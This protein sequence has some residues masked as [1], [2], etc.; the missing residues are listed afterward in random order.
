[1]I[2][3]ARNYKQAVIA[4]TGAYQY[5]DVIV[6]AI[7]PVAKNASDA[8]KT[9]LMIDQFNQELAKMC[10]DEG[11]KYLNLTEAL[12]DSNSGYAEAAY[13]NNKQNG[14][15]TSG[16]NVVLN[17][18]RN[19]AYD[20]AD[21]RPNTDDI[22]QRTEQAGGSAA[23]TEP[24]PS[25]TPTTFKL[26][27]LVEEGK[28]TLQGNDQSGVTS[29]EMDAAEKQTV[30]ITAVA[31]DGYTFYKWSDGL[32]TATRVDSATKDISVTA[33]FNDARVQINLDQGESTIKQGESLTINASVTLGGKSYDNSGVQWSVNDDLMQN[34]A[35]LYLYAECHRRLP[36]QGRAGSQRYLYF[37]GT[38]GACA[39]TGY[40]RQHH[41]CQLHAG[42]QYHNAAGQR[43]QSFGGYRLDLRPEAAVECNRR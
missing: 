3:F 8:A 6:C 31:A 25:A 13:L 21:T 36:H 40:H 7:P 27:Y 38:D 35:S 32:T 26:Q 43:K 17:Y 24:T 28:G 41:R 33:M 42:R 14:F 30:T 4:I 19:H 37:A 5:C 20:T 18:L 9:Q 22:P 29:I 1:M 12:K 10:N 34:G 11:Y 23:A 16:A 2:I 15:S 39:G